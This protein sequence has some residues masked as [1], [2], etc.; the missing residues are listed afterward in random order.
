MAKALLVA[1]CIIAV[2]GLGRGDETEDN[3]KAAYS[4]SLRLGDDGT[5]RLA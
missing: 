1:L 5:V 4:A 3:K 2:M